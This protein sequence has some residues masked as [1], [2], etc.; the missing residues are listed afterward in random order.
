[1]R[2]GTLAAAFLVVLPVVMC[3]LDVL[4]LGAFVAIAQQQ[5]QR[6]AIL[7]AIDAIA[8]AVVDGQLE[9]AAPYRFPVA[10]QARLHAVESGH[11]ARPGLPIPQVAQPLAEWAA[12]VRRL[13]LAYL[14]ERYCSL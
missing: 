7:P 14:E 11:D 3:H 10:T 1:M 5:H 9:H 12:S 8:R 6:L 2:T 13:V 4:L